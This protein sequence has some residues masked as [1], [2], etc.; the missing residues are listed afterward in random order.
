MKKSVLMAITLLLSVVNV[1]AQ[2]EMPTVTV[3]YNGNSAQVTIPATAVGV[4]CTSGTSSH[5]KISNTNATTEYCVRLRGS[6]TNG[7]FWYSAKYKMTMEL[8]GVNITNP[9]GAAIDNQCGKRIDVKLIKGTVSNIMDGTGSDHKAAMYFKGHPEFKG[10][11]TLNVTG[12]YA[13]AIS[14][15]EYILLKENLGTLNILG[16][17]KDGLHCGTGVGDAEKDYFQMDGGNVTISNCKSNA[18]DSDDFGTMAFTG[19]IMTIHASS[20]DA[21]A[22]NCDGEMTVTGTA[23]IILE[24]DYYKCDDAKYQYDMTANIQLQKSGEIVDYTRY[25]LGAFVDGECRGVGTM[26]ITPA[27]R[28]ATIRIRSNKTNG[29]K[30]RFK[31]YNANKQRDN[32]AL[33]S[34]T[35]QDNQIVGQPSQPK[36]INLSTADIVTMASWISMLKSSKTTIEDVN[37]IRQVVLKK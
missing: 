36:V 29:E 30:V 17:V 8:D 32:V 31:A 26:Y 10:G 14:A 33:E 6:T 19:G 5:V 16:A 28:Y 3:V 2:D 1:M 4:T 27:A 20:P 7:S 23:Q 37:F 13:H 11:G 21:E 18:V 24:G 9:N 25:Q 22:I 34:V 15:K 35:F 12:V